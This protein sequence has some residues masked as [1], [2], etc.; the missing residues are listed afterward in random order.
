MGENTT[1]TVN[2]VNN[3][4]TQ[5]LIELRIVYGSAELVFYDQIT[6]T[7]LDGPEYNGYNYTIYYPKTRKMNTDEQWGIPILIEGLDPGGSSYTYTIY[8][9]IYSDNAFSERQSIQ[10]TVKRP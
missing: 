9:E 6:K 3:A 1:L 5:K 8:L 7:L 2:I 10:L 4:P